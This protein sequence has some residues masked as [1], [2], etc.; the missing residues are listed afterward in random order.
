MFR[1]FLASAG[2]TLFGMS[3][4]CA[5]FA[6]A[7]QLQSQPVTIDDLATRA[8]IVLA[9]MSPDGRRAAYL[10]ARGNPARDS[11]AMTLH[12]VATEPKSS[13]AL[14]ASYELGGGDVFDDHGQLRPSAGGL[15]WSAQN[16]LLF[17]D[18]GGEQ[19]R[20]L[21]WTPGGPGVRVVLEH[22]DKILLDDC[23]R[24]QQAM[25]VLTRDV[26]APNI[27]SEGGVGDY[28]WRMTDEDRFYGER[29]NLK[30]GPFVRDQKWSVMFDEK[31]SASVQ[32]AGEPQQRWQRE[33]PWKPYER[34]YTPGAEVV[35]TQ[36]EQTFPDDQVA[37][38]NGSRVAFVQYRATNLD[39]PGASDTDVSIVLSSDGK[40]STLVPASRRNL[41]IVGWAGD[42]GPVY[43]LETHH[44]GSA[45]HRVALSGRISAITGSSGLFEKPCKRFGRR[46]QVMGGN[47][48]LA[49][50]I[51]STNTTPDELVLVDL[52]HGGGVHALAAPNAGFHA[53][54]LPAVRFYE[55]E[56]LRGK[57]WGRLYLPTDYRSGSRYP[58]VI[59]LYLSSP[60]FHA[61]IGDE[62]PILPLT[63][64][65][66]AVFAMNAAS[67]G[68][69]SKSGDFRVE[70]ERV[71]EPLR[72][73]HWIIEKLTEQGIIDPRRV[74]ITGLSYGAEIAMYAYGKTNRFAAVSTASASWN[75]SLFAL[76][77]RLYAQTLLER[78]LTATGDEAGL[79]NWNQLAVSLKPRPDLPPLLIQSSEGEEVFTAPTWTELRLAG[80]PVEWYDYPEA[81]SGHVKARPANK[82]WVYRRNLDWFRF[83]LQDYVDPVA[84]KSEQ[85]QRWRQLRELRDAQ[86]TA[87]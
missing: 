85:Y 44:D 25:T 2:A 82:W 69:G 18:K 72:G 83:W 15:C 48:R 49:L 56:N 8:H 54:Q 11:Y 71:E 33:P 78:G 59:T 32:A 14:I 63:A 4:A 84:E 75:P 65:G 13:P 1:K 66:I 34:P 12:A 64:S 60:G 73:L 19:M 23:D 7:P 28:S 80:A 57:A 40:A 76:G 61:S 47:G 67:L 58:L 20:L 45:L 17:T 6:P 22:H 41:S 3:S 31:G 24:V 27:A 50:L 42:Q 38:P 43:F 9:A 10:I 52:R 5:A 30:S 37:S 77:G 39:Q 21:A 46:C 36:S 87:R 62:V 29:P 16:E 35:D 70:L 74:G 51:R 79:K 81:E 86:G 53:K 55:L 68:W 26:I